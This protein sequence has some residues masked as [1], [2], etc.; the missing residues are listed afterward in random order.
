MGSLSI[1]KMASIFGA[2]FLASLSPCVYPLIPVTLG[3]FGTQKKF[4]RL[5]ILLYVVGQML[6]FTT[7][8]VIAVKSGKSL[9]FTS[10]SYVVNLVFGLSM[11]VFGY[12]SYLGRLPK[13]FKVFDRVSVNPSQNFGGFVAP[14]LL[15]ITSALIASPCTTPLLSAVMILLADSAT[16][17]SGVFLMLLYSLGF[18]LLIMGLA[19]GVLNMD[20]LPKSGNWLNIVHKIS[21]FLLIA[22]GLYYLYLSWDIYRF[23]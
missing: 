4:S 3:Y 13:F 12:Y 16:I 5:K 19:F 10:Q 17:M 11:L 8:A 9:G 22:L 23:M 15:G 7:L 2:G 14:L 6:T 18:S 21:A 20:K 1:L